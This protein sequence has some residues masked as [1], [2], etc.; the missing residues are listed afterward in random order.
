MMDDIF[1]FSKQVGI[2]VDD[3]E[4]A[5]QE[6]RKHGYLFTYAKN[7]TEFASHKYPIR[8]IGMPPNDPEKPS[9][10][11]F[12]PFAMKRTR[13]EEIKSTLSPTEPDTF[14]ILL[15]YYRLMYEKTGTQ[16]INYS[17]SKNSDLPP[18]EYM[19]LSMTTLWDLDNPVVF[20]DYVWFVPTDKVKEMI[21][22]DNN[23]AFKKNDFSWW[24]YKWDMGT[25]MELTTMS[26]YPELYHLIPNYF[27]DTWGL[28]LP[29][30]ATGA[31]F[32]MY[33]SMVGSDTLISVKSTQK[34]LELIEQGINNILGESSM[35]Y[36]SSIDKELLLKELC[37]YNDIPYPVDAFTTLDYLTRMG[38]VTV[39]QEKSGISY[40]I[41]I[42]APRPNS[43]FRFPNKWKKR[44]D[45]YIEKGTVLFSYLTINEII[46]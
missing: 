14:K 4:K 44:M 6:L 32:S 19:F 18:S 23:V 33:R 8:V 35:K 28:Y 26:D 7:A 43:I 45:Q 27:L 34:I 17:F 38:L 10:V 40:Q 24:N 39:T 31:L 3:T 5:F 36:E 13:Y 42:N 46:Q 25:D 2:S 15:G 30:I 12:G 41:P 20:D 37:D 11:S 22:E 16:E 29:G 1:A 21:E 9:V